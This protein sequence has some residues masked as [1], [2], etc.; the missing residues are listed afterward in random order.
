MAVYAGSVTGLTL[1]L[2]AATGAWPDWGGYLEYIHLYTISNFGDLL[3]APWSAGLAIG[4][5]YTVSA[6]LLLL[7]VIICPAFARSRAVALRAATGL[8]AL[9]ILV[10]TY[11][12]GRS[13]PNNL[14]HISPPAI[15]LLFVWL[16]MARSTVSS[17]VPIAAVSAVAALFA[18]L[19][20][21]G[22]HQ[23]ITQKYTST[24][25]ASVLGSSKSLDSRVSALWHN[26]V[27]EPAVTDIVRFVA[28]LRTHG[29]PLTIL[30]PQAVETEVLLRL[31]AINAIGSSNPLQEEISPG[32]RTRIA[33]AVRVL[34]PGG[35]LVI[36]VTESALPIEQY[37]FA[38]LNQRFTLRA[39]GTSRHG[40]RAYMM[41]LAH[42]QEAGG[43]Q[44]L[45]NT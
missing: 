45:P 3:I 10:Y 42:S 32:P 27:V 29:A 44:A 13:H 14:V 36:S 43:R 15:A 2:R 19:I 33:A 41:V 30:L 37:E 24:A 21:T 40:L 17:R 6:V 18:A 16:D 12:L 1:I 9:G 31:D 22:E 34:P 39:I 25:L 23:N 35:I 38:L 8:T 5:L 20:V 7:I 26:P 4:G 28:S 11:F